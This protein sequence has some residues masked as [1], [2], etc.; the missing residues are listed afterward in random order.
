MADI[1]E[2]LYA[3]CKAR[4]YMVEELE[5]KCRGKSEERGAFDKKP[6]LKYVI[7]H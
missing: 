6:Y 5:A 3:I 7:S 1:L 4:G 2:V